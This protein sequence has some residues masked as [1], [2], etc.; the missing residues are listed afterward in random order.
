M[1]KV[2]G[3]VFPVARKANVPVWLQGP[4]FSP[5]GEVRGLHQN[6]VIEKHELLPS[7]PSDSLARA[8]KHGGLALVLM[9]N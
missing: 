2:S 4:R 8:G 9:G 6:F 5:T 3:P 7:L 1:E